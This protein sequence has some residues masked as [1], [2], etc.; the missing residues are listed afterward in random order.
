MEN[1]ICPLKLG[2]RYYNFII[3]KCL[4][5]QTIIKLNLNDMLLI[6]N[7]S[8]ANVFAKDRAEYIFGEAL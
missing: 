1:L 6:G 4:L 8:L 2:Q 3:A 5:T 7:F